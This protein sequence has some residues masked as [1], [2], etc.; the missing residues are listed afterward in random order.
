MKTLEY[1]D[2]YKPVYSRER[3]KPLV[4]FLKNKNN[5]SFCEFGCG[6]AVNLKEIAKV[7]K[8]VNFT[9][10][11]GSAA[12]GENWPFDKRDFHVCSVLDEREMKKFERKFDYVLMAHLLHHLIGHSRGESI[13]NARKCLCIAR[14]SLNKNGKIILLEPIFRPYFLMT[15]LFYIKKTFCIFSSRRVAL[16]DQ[17]NNLG[18]PVVSYFDEEHLKEVIDRV[19]LKIKIFKQNQSKRNTI[20]R[21]FGIKR[22]EVFIVLS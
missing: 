14:R 11:E 16:F 21:I 20:F 8:K 1:F 9:G 7:T 3:A 15:L 13:A 22:S 4:E 12:Y 17:W 10:I 18:A 2:L 19:G 6:N 5:F